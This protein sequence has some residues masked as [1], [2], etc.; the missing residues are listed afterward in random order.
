MNKRYFFIFALYVGIQSF[1]LQLI[2]QLIGKSLVPGGHNGFVFIAFQGWALYFL[3][4][5]TLRGAVTG[6]CGY[7]MGILF[8]VLMIAAASAF[9][10]LRL[11][12]VPVTALVIVPVMMY[13]EYAPWLVSNV[14]SFFVGA[15]AFYGVLNYVDGIRILEAAWIV[16]LYCSLGLI[17]GWMTIWFRKQYEDRINAKK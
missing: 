8:A 5:S 1:L 11:L 6:F 17:S 2:D 10:G 15:G 12:A 9:S 16:L 7:V 14:A 4:G 13:F 3:H